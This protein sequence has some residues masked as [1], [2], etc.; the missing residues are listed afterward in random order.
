LK[1]WLLW[2]YFI[3]GWVIGDVDVLVELVIEVGL[4][5]ECVWEVFV[6]GEYVVDVCVD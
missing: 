2:V 5:V 4:F 3:E 6:L 1:E